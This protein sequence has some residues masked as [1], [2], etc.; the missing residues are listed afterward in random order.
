MTCVIRDVPA[1]L[2]Q[3]TIPDVVQSLGDSNVKPEIS[4]CACA[5]RRPDDLRR[6]LESL[7]NQVSQTPAY[8]VIVVDNDAA[9]T[10]AAAAGEF[11]DAR[12]PVRYFVEPEQNISRA[13]NRSLAEAK[14]DL[15]AIIDDD[16][17]AKPDWLLELH[18]ALLDH[19]ADAAFGPVHSWFVAPPPQWII[20]GGFFDYSPIPT[21]QVMPLESTRT[22]NV[23]LR[24]SA[25]PG[26]D[27]VFD[28]NLGLTGGEDIDLFRRMQEGN[29]H[30][31]AVE[32]AVVHETV[33][34][35]RAC[36][37]WLSARW[38]RY[39]TMRVDVHENKRDS[40]RFMVATSGRATAGFFVNLAGAAR[41]A[42]FRKARSAEYFLRA[43]YWAG[44]IANIVGYTY[45]EYK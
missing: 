37:K 29:A 45:E 2:E 22:S 40:L 38:F 23:L 13:R 36:L 41:K 31:I 18:R 11:A 21:G 4:V 6:L 32:S 30:L 27:D 33:P 5:Y 8:E 9:G 7:V 3:A 10:S 14:G 12:I 25:L 26:P 19:E 28:V 42:P 20:D 39:G 34:E 1:A 16:E 17:I 35:K 43:C 24:R 44:V 15:I